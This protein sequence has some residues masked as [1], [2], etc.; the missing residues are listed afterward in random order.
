MPACDEVNT[1]W[2][3]VCTN[4]TSPENARDAKSSSKSSITQTPTRLSS[5]T[6]V[7]ADDGDKIALRPLFP[8]AGD[9]PL[10]N[11]VLGNILAWL[12]SVDMAALFRSSRA[13]ACSPG[14][15]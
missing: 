11:E 13:W 7:K 1:S 14:E 2:T 8:A 15:L 10:A 3:V 5:V 6:V 4:T 12:R 9:R